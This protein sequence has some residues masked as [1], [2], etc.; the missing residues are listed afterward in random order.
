[1]STEPNCHDKAGA[2]TND[3]AAALA[4]YSH[5]QV[6]TLEVRRAFS[7]RGVSGRVVSGLL[8]AAG[9][10][11]RIR[12]VRTYGRVTGSTFYEMTPLQLRQIQEE[13]IRRGDKTSNLARGPECGGR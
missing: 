5:D 1:M 8:K 7:Q 11:G 3:V 12:V 2:G 13:A 4:L 9:K 6:A 10:S